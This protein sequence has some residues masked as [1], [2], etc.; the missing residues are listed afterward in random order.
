MSRPVVRSF[1]SPNKIEIV[2][3]KINKLQD[4]LERYVQPLQKSSGY[5][6]GRTILGG[7]T[8]CKILFVHIPFWC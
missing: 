1:L 2:T 3:L 8:I 6:L 5:G 4:S 7:E